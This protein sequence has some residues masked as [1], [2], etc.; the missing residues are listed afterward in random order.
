MSVIFEINRDFPYQIALPFDEDAVDV[1][2]WLEG[3][4]LPPRRVKGL[5]TESLLASTIA[6]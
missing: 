5:S 6:F 2:D 3:R 1:L 4:G